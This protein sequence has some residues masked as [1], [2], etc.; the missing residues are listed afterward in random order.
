VGGRLPLLAAMAEL[1]V[2][3]R[4]RQGS[5][6]GLLHL[7]KDVAGEYQRGVRFPTQSANLEYRRR[8]SGSQWGDVEG[9][10]RQMQQCHH[11]C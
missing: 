11:V 6:G 2:V 7:A 9:A 8:R 4:H 3:D 10:D 1:L 5:R